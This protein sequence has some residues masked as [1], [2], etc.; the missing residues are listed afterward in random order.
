[1]LALS[2]TGLAGGQYETSGKNPGARTSMR[3]NL[4]DHGGNPAGMEFSS[5][6]MHVLCWWLPQPPVGDYDKI[7]GKCV[8]F[9][10]TGTVVSSA[11]GPN[12][13]LA[14]EY[15][16]QFPTTASRQHFE[17]FLADTNSASVC[18]WGFSLDY[19]LGFRFLKHEGYSSP[20]E[21]ELWRL[22]PSPERRWR[23]RLPE[24]ISK[25]GL[26]GFFDTD[27]RDRL[28]VAFVG[29]NAYVFSTS[30]G[31]MLDSFV[32]ASPPQ[33]VKGQP[34]NKLSDLP[35]ADRAPIPSFLAGVLSFDSSRRLLACGADEGKHI[36]VLSANPPHGVVFEAHVGENPRRPSG[37][38][39]LVD[40]LHFSGGG[41]YLMAG[42]KFGGRA[43]KKSLSMVEIFDTSS[44][45]TVWSTE[46]A[47]IS[48]MVPPKLSPD[49][50][51]LALIRGH[52][53][54]ISP[55]RSTR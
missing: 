55:F 12:G 45:R 27:A 13:H 36:R 43:T 40:S 30:D 24:E 11:N 29:M 14:S 8:V 49:G 5:D 52:W 19:S 54:E 25:R 21:G 41:R 46:D 4:M 10:L 47:E 1:M 23:L 42:Y 28:L 17:W 38:L 32:Y 7:L 44:W 50:K 3:A 35:L 9:D 37:G 6:G 2:S 18:L 20:G 39:W 34:R 22:S 16:M 31:T 33:E 53:L 48:P 51:T 15:V 26:A